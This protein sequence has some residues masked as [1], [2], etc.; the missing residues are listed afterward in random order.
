MSVRV[1]SLGD[2]RRKRLGM[3]GD[4]PADYFAIGGGTAKTEALRVQILEEFDETV[5]AYFAAGGQ[6]VLYDANNGQEKVRQALRDKFEPEGVSVMFLESV[7][8]DV[9]LIEHNVRAVKLRSPDYRGWNQSDAMKD[10]YQRIQS[11]QAE[12]ETISNPSFPYVKIINAGERV[13]VNNIQGYL[14][15]R[16]CFFDECA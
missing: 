14:Q 16:I 11:R 10:F 1:F 15:S 5:R 12:Y 6:V 13:V 7:C 9:R 8:D 4:L 2:Y 3:P